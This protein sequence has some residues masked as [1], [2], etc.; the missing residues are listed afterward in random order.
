MQDPTNSQQCVRGQPTTL[1]E[2]APASRCTSQLLSS[3]GHSSVGMAARGR[4]WPQ[5]GV[6][7]S[8]LG[9]ISEESGHLSHN[10]IE[11]I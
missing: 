7:G 1:S 10:R 6:P 11:G 3:S 2:S 8:L 5:E 4:V 9:E